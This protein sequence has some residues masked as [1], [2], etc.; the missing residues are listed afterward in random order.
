MKIT[1]FTQYTRFGKAE[2]PVKTPVKPKPLT[3]NL[4]E[5]LPFTPSPFQPPKPQVNPDKKHTT[6]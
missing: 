2:A 3:P 5:K 4:P 6:C 1:P